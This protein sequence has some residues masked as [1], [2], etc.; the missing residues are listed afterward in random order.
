[1]DSLMSRPLTPC[2]ERTIL[3]KW[4]GQL[5]PEPVRAFWR[6]KKMPFPPLGIEPSH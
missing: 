2:K 1:M 3:I 4:W 5:A 6:E